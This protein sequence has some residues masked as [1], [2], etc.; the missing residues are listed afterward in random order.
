VTA[1]GRAAN[2]PLFLSST[3]E[4]VLASGV[5]AGLGLVDD[6]GL[7]R[8]YLPKEQD[9]VLKL[10]SST[11]SSTA[12]KDA[13]ILKLVE[14]VMSGVHLAAT[15]EAMSLGKKVGLDTKQLFEIIAGAAGNSAEFKNATPQL[16]S[17]SWT[18]EKTV[19]GVIAELV[20]VLLMTFSSC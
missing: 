7:V 13:K 9:L 10:A 1:G 20:R 2:F 12:L 4:Q 3:T 16:L 19:K 17:G 14:Q 5:S 15:A 8:V 6:S 11:S 18:S